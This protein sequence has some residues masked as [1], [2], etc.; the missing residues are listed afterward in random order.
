MDRSRRELE[1]LARASAHARGHCL[2]IFRTTSTDE[3]RVCAM[4]TCGY[5]HA[6]ACI[7]TNPPP[8]GIDVGGRAVAI[9]CTRRIE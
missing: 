4:A 8:N 6:E 2:S 7:D 1:Q 9:N 5:C 3:R